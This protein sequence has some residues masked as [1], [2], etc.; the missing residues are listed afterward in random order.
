MQEEL[1]MN[2]LVIVILSHYEPE[3][4]ALFFFQVPQCMHMI[5][6]EIKKKKKKKHIR[7]RGKV[8][9]SNPMGKNLYIVTQHK[10]VHLFCNLLSQYVTSQIIAMS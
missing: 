6:K 3:S 1:E 7:I 10:L 4:R 5:E 8:Q 9:V 2:H